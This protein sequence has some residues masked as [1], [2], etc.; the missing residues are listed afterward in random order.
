MK[1]DGLRC[2]LCGQTADDGVKLV[3]DHIKPVSKGGLTEMEN[4][5]TLCDRC[6]SGKSDLWDENG[7]N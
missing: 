2:T 5:R 3:V 1:R 4:L 7:L 6:N